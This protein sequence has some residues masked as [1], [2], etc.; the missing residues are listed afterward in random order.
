VQKKCRII[1][2]LDIPSCFID[3]EIQKISSVTILPIL[4]PILYFD[5]L[6]DLQELQ[7]FTSIEKSERFI[8]M[9][10]KRISEVI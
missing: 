6:G 8:K 2:N 9:K 7:T 5:Y 1:S 3:R 10:E 4:F